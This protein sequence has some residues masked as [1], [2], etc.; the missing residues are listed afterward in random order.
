ML[1][2]QE[3]STN[4]LSYRLSVLQQHRLRHVTSL[5]IRNLA[6]SLPTNEN[7]GSDLQQPLLYFTIHPDETSLIADKQCR[8]SIDVLY[9]SE[10]VSY[11]T[12]PSWQ[13][14]KIKNAEF[15]K[16]FILRLWIG[17]DLSYMPA[18][19]LQ[20]SLKMLQCLGDS[21][22]N[23]AVYYHSNAVV[24]KMGNFYH[25][26]NTSLYGA[27]GSAILH[28]IDIHNSY[29]VF[30]LQRILA[31]CKLNVCSNQNRNLHHQQINIH[32]IGNTAV[33]RLKVGLESLRNRIKNLQ[34]LLKTE[35]A[36]LNKEREDLDVERWKRKQS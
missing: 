28:N 35:K 23:E 34:H 9:E 1:N 3:I 7:C 25:G 26:H 11:S 27:I 14:I 18:L 19:H 13:S 22:Y 36:I 16:E 29:S 5:F 10:K 2:E 6:I 24:F 20:I 15:I 33:T 17:H 32:L 21:L 8:N 30:S 4:N 12:N 31:R